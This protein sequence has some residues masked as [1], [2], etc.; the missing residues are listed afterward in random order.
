[1][2]PKIP[3]VPSQFQQGIDTTLSPA[4]IFKC[5]DFTESAEFD[6]DETDERK[7][8]PLA[9]ALAMVM[10]GRIKDVLTIVGLMANDRINNRG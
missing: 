5:T 3:A 10:D 7:W 6:N 9:D 2:N 4:E 8:F 1:L